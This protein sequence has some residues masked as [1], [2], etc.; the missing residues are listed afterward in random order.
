MVGSRLSHVLGRSQDG[1]EDGAGDSSANRASLEV[2]TRGAARERGEGGR[3]WTDQLA[4]LYSTT[5]LLRDGVG[6]FR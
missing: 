5:D 6:E 2:W 4:G 3:G 1:G